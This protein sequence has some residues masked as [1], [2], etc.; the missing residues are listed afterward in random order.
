MTVANVAPAVTITAPA[1][2][3]VVPTGSTVDFAADFTDAGA[4]DTHT[5]TLDFGDG[6]PVANG[7]VNG[8]TCT[9]SH[10]FTVSGTRD[11]VVTVTD[12]DG[13]SATDT[14]RVIVNSAPEVDAGG[15]YSGQEGAS[16]AIAGAV[17]DRTGR[18]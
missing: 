4:N 10:V 13:G 6:T 18:S 17:T 2:E 11:V 5:C 1:N 8:D 3:V 14:V 16:I 12:D 7:T 15:P 9:A